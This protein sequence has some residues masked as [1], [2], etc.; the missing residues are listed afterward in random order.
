[1]VFHYVFT[2]IGY[3]S[4]TDYVTYNLF[5]FAIICILHKMYASRMSNVIF[6]ANNLL[7]FYVTCN[8][9]AIGINVCAAW[10]FI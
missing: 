6:D 8:G 7:F 1:M 2:Y 3:L 9:L 4:L 10:L 5:L